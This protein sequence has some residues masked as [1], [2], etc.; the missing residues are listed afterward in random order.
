MGMSR[1]NLAVA[2]IVLLDAKR[3]PR[4]AAM[5]GRGDEFF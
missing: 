3:F 1:N 4:P 5:N 2:G